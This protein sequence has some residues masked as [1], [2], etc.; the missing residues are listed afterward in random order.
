MKR[1]GAVS[2]EEAARM[3]GVSE[4]TIDR[5][6]KDGRLVK[7]HIRGTARITLESIDRWQ[8]ELEGREA[9]TATVSRNRFF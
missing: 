9:T 7:V 3:Y 5:E 1:L 2:V 8:R 4:S 6:V